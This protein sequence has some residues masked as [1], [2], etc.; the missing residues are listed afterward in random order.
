MS[1]LIKSRV[2][3]FQDVLNLVRPTQFGT[4]PNKLSAYPHRCGAAP[5]RLFETTLG[6][7]FRRGRLITVLESGG[8]GIHGPGADLLVFR[9]PAMLPRVQAMRLGRHGITEIVRQP[10]QE[11]AQ[12]ASVAVQLPSFTERVPPGKKILD[13][14]AVPA[15]F[16]EELTRRCARKD[17]CHV[18]DHRVEVF[19]CPRAE[20]AGFGTAGEL[21]WLPQPTA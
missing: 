7:I 15:D 18:R 21:Q 2:S 5:G 9:L 14:K 16:A 10:G 12:R 1:E 3:V 19:Q 13:L 11:N 4:S 20:L 6:C 8:F 17:G